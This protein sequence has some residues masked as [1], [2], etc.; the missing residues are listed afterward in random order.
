MQQSIHIIVRKAGGL[1]ILFLALSLVTRCKKEPDDGIIM[2]VMGP[3][4]ASRLGISLTHEHVLVDFIGADSVSE[5]RWDREEVVKAALPF[6]RQVKDLGCNSFFEC[7]PSYLG[8]DPLI[9]KALSDSTGMNFIT[10]TGYYGAGQNSKFI[11][12]HGFTESADQ[13]SQRWTKEWEEG[14]NGTGIKPGFIKIAVIGDPLTDMDIKLV[15]AAALTHLETGLTIA[16]HTGPAALAFGE[17][18]ILKK[19]GVSP[20]AF[21]WVHA[22]SEK[23]INRL[24]EGARAG[25][26]ISIDNLNENNVAEIAGKI[27]SLKDNGLLGKV[28]ISHDAGWYDPALENGGEYRGYNILFEK[29]LPALRLEGF[30][31]EEINTLLVKN[32]ADAFRVRIR[33]L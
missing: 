6:I 20:E 25:A 2:T 15:R 11:P 9:L 30:T 28:L 4:P 33:K 3:V 7:T 32:P 24:V 31:E 29:L 10:N 27:S 5:S 19:E 22:G 18:D 16:S 23:D 17:L 26:W 13:L 12:D 8:K 21:I 14:I 1:L